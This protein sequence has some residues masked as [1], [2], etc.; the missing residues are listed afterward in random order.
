M[1]VLVTHIGLLM[2]VVYNVVKH[3]D[4]HTTGLP[5]RAGTRNWFLALSAE[6]LQ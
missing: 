5:A 3:R 4:L 2:L 6:L 1:S